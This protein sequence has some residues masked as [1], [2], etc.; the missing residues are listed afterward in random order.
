MK[1]IPAVKTINFN[2]FILLIPNQDVPSQQI[3]RTNYSKNM[4]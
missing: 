4:N 3:N 2:I 1:R